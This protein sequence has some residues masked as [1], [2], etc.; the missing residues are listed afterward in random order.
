VKGIRAGRFCQGDHRTLTTETSNP[1]GI[2]SP[3]TFAA[4]G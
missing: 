3:F 4:P 2:Q 1:L